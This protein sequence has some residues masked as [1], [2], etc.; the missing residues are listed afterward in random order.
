VHKQSARREN[1]GRL[2]RA[3]RLLENNMTRQIF[4]SAP[5]GARKLAAFDAQWKR[6]RGDHRLPGIK[7][8]RDKFTAH[9]G[10]PKDI[11]EVTY[12]DI[13]EFGEATAKLMELVGRVEGNRGTCARSALRTAATLTESGFG[14]MALSLAG[15]IDESE[16]V[17][18][19]AVLSFR[20]GRLSE[21]KLWPPQFFGPIPCFRGRN[22]IK[23]RKTACTCHRPP[24]LVQP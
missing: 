16:P 22:G 7:D 4:A 21:V 10:E 19:A 14:D 8:F 20:E 15:Q 18:V 3:A 13:F 12:R 6:C 23:T 11:D 24:F 5:D 9:L 1:S 2:R 17:I